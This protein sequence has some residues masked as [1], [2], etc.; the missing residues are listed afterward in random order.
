MDSDLSMWF[1]DNSHIYVV[2]NH[3]CWLDPDTNRKV[4][5]RRYGTVVRSTEA[6]LAGMLAAHLDETEKW[7]LDRV[8]EPQADED[9]DGGG[10]NGG[11]T[12]EEERAN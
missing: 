11:D 4:A 9:D 12:T 3:A 2:S 5:K 8:A 7:I 6:S 10:R 1:K